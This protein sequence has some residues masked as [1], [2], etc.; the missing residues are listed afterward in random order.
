MPL[1]YENPD[2]QQA[3]QHIAATCRENDVAP[4][5]YFVPPGIEPAELI[6]WGFQFFTMAW[7]GWAK[8]GISEGLSSIT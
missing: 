7:Q 1:E 8:A 5:V 4:G 3:L 2:Y 6:D